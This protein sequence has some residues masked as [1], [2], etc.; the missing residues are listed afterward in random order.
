VSNHEAGCDV[1]EVVS[2]QELEDA[3]FDDLR[4]HVESMI[5]WARSE[6]SLGMQNAPLEEH[7]LARGYRA[8]QLLTEAHL[9]VRTVREQRRGRC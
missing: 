5:V 8:V 6:A 1:D 7:A 2:A 9:K 4:A 3:L